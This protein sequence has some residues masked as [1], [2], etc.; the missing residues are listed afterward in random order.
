MRRTQVQLTDEQLQRL[1]EL[2][3]RQGRSVADV[4]RESVDSYIARTERDREELYERA[5]NIIGKYSGPPDLAENHD[6]YYVQTIE[7]HLKES[8]RR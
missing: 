2:A 5:R 6:E 3:Q 4:I 7:E 1:R 8:R